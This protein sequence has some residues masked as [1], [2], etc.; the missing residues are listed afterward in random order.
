MDT[1]ACRKVKRKVDH[2]PHTW[3]QGRYLPTGDTGEQVWCPGYLEPAC[4]C[5]EHREHAPV[6]GGPHHYRLNIDWD[7]RLGERWRWA[8]DC[9]SVGNWN[10]Q[11]A[12]AAYHAWLR[13]MDKNDLEPIAIDRQAR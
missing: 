11:S 13:H 2:L 12:W 8:C 1:A 10:Y 5:A 4:G 3:T 7:Y 9:G 6:D